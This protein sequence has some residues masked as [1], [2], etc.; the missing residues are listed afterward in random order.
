MI[1]KIIVEQQMI[2]Q[3][4]YWKLPMTSQDIHGDGVKGMP[5]SMGFILYCWYSYGLL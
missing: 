2:T 3:K 1:L 5:W 4:A